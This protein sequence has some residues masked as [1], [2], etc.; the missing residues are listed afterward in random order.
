MHE[1]CS[2]V[3]IQRQF[4]SAMSI[5]LSIVGT[6]NASLAIV[7]LARLGDEVLKSS[8][9]LLALSVFDLLSCS[10]LLPDY[11]F[12]ISYPN[13]Y[14]ELLANTSLH[15][16]VWHMFLCTFIYWSFLYSQLGLSIERMMFV[17]WPFQ[18]EERR[19][20]NMIYRIAVV[21]TILWCFAWSV[22]MA[23]DANHWLHNETYVELGDGVRC[24][25]EIKRV[26]YVDIIVFQIL[27]LVGALL[28][29]IVVVRVTRASQGR[30]HS[31]TM[32]ISTKHKPEGDMSFLR[33]TY[34]SLSSNFGGRSTKACNMLISVN[35][36]SLVT[37]PLRGLFEL[38]DGAPSLHQPYGLATGSKCK[39][40]I[41]TDWL[42]LISYCNNQNWILYLLIS[43]RFRHAY[44]YLWFK[45]LPQRM[46]SWMSRTSENE[47]PIL[48]I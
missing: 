17:L 36:L 21:L 42:I 40:Q 4:L 31:L 32:H 41:I 9:W 27:P 46:P 15:I 13:M 25:G 16:C 10:I 26:G 7:I 37:A 6:V 39:S 43:D 30:V 28:C 2:A 3:D 20:S 29:T 12:S 18:C 33:R 24:I 11:V 47:L 19:N 22:G 44:A 45:M 38:V 34:S 35:V 23:Y 14:H 8:R 1:N 48:E 5:C